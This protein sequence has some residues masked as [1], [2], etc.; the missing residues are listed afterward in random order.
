MGK[1]KDGTSQFEVTVKGYVGLGPAV[2]SNL[3]KKQE[4]NIS[5]QKQLLRMLRV[6]YEKSVGND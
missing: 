1:I 6:A 2:I 5:V 3:I 4:V